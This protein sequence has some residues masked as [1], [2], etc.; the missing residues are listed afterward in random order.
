MCLD[1]PGGN[2]GE[3]RGEGLR[4]GSGHHPDLQRR[5]QDA[6][7]RHADVARH[8]GGSGPGRRSG[9]P[10]QLAALLSSPLSCSLSL[11]GSSFSM[12]VGTLESNVL[13]ARPRQLSGLFRLRPFHF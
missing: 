8:Q 3:V 10:W 11:S 6:S 9:S 13:L 1:L 5:A 4:P 7:E 2:A 12:L